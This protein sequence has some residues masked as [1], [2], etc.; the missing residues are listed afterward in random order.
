[1][2][3]RDRYIA[4][5]SRRDV[6]VEIVDNYFETIVNQVTSR[7]DVRVEITEEGDKIR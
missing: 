7:R 1:M 4:V 3:I 2:C 6:R 5:T